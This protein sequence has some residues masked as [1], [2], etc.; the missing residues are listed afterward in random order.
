MSELSIR[1]EQIEGLEEFLRMIV[2][3]EIARP[4]LV[5]D[6]E[7]LKKTP[8]G[9]VIRLEEQVK[10]IAEDVGEIKSHISN[11]ENRMSNLENRMMAKF[12]D[13]ES[14]MATKDDLSQLANKFDNLESRMLTKFDDI[15]SRM[16][17][18]DDLSQLANKFDNLESRMA[19]KDQLA[20]FATKNEL[21][22]LA[23]RIEG[24][25][26]TLDVRIE[27]QGK[28]LSFFQV[29][30]YSMFGVLFAMIVAIL[31]KLFF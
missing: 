17:T 7:Q 27:E 24:L 31:I 23:Q 22:I 21:N 1:A 8:A 5:E 16:A 2:R 10:A 11:V 3:E 30:T 4:P 12:D 9:A 6:V 26:N 13:I 18:K 15:E 29:V 14:R 28:R 19:T 25:I 20:Q